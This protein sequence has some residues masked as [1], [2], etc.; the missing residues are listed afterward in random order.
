VRE[1]DVA[2]DRVRVRQRQYAI[3]LRDGPGPKV[4]HTQNVLN[5]IVLAGV[6]E[7]DGVALL[8]H[9]DVNSSNQAIDDLLRALREF[10]YDTPEKARRFR[11]HWVCGIGTWFLPLGVTLA[12]AATYGALSWNGHSAELLSFAAGSLA[13]TFWYSTNLWFVRLKVWKSGKLGRL[14]PM[15]KPGWLPLWN[16]GATVTIGPN[17]IDVR[18]KKMYTKTRWNRH[19]A[20]LYTV[21]PGA[22]KWHL[23]AA[24]GSTPS[25]LNRAPSA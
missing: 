2:S 16:T 23:A 17:T 4:L 18:A 22:D 9:I 21:A 6:N 10:R 3:A 12:G 19:D 7:E 13:I 20:D 14:V 25:P 15:V 8:A 11:I 1:E 5:C 24:E